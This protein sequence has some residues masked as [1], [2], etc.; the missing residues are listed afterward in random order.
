MSN[1]MYKITREI[2]VILSCLESLILF[3]QSYS[4]RAIMNLILLALFLHTSYYFEKKYSKITVSY[5]FVFLIVYFIDSLTA[6]ACTEKMLGQLNDDKTFGFW[7]GDYY[8]IYFVSII[9]V[10]TVILFY[11]KISNNNQPEIKNKNE[12][13]NENNPNYYIVGCVILI[14]IHVALN[15]YEAIIPVYSYLIH[16]LFF[17]KRN[18][19]KCLIVLL[20]TVILTRGILLQRYK[21]VEI[22]LPIVLMFLV[23]QKDKG[24]INI[25]KVNVLAFAGVLVAGLYG[26]ASEVYKLNKNY[27]GQYSL[28]DIITNSQSLFQ[29]FYRQ[30]YR[31]FAIWIKLG[32]YIIYHTKSYGYYYGI[33]YVKP[34]SKVIGFEYVSLPKISAMYDGANYAQ[35]GLLAEGYA[36]FGIVGASINILAVFFFMEYT[37]KKYRNYP[38]VINL[39]YVVVPFAQILLDGG[40]LNSALYLYI[41]CMILNVI[42]L[43]Q[44]SKKRDRGKNY[45]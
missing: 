5:L 27:N 17:D 13:L 29:F 38:S 8:N 43:I 10:Y 9:I 23:K 42:N 41:M 25:I 26:V 19:T 7:I 15:S 40:T 12:L 37:W 4:N 1:A 11:L 6:C 44:N 20:I 31:V 35:P 33:T 14:G 3:N 18:R 36:N 21:F 32:G 34:L 2:A 22:A 16:Q 30:F 45:E 28:Q 39:L 24:K